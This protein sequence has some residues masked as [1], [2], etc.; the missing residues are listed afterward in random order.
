LDLTELPAVVA[1]DY[2]L[3]RV[4]GIVEGEADMPY[5]ARCPG[6]LEGGQGAQLLDL[7]PSL[8]PEGVEEVEI[9]SVGP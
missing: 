2:L 7:R 3:E 8:G 6:A 4:Q 1:V 9:Y 5:L